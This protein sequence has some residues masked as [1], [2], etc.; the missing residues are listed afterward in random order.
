MNTILVCD[1]NGQII[2]KQCQSCLHSCLTAAISFD[3]A[4][5]GHVLLSTIHTNDSVSA[6]SRL[7]DLGIDYNQIASSLICV[8]SQRLVR[9]NCSK[10]SR[11]F[12]PP[13]EEVQLF[14]NKYPSHLKFYK[15]TG[16]KACDFTGYSGRTVISELFE[17]NREIAFAISS[18]TS[19]T[20]LK[21]IAIKAGMKTM[22]DDGFM[23]TDQISLSELIRVIPIEMIKEFKSRN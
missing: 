10:C 3:A 21:Q 12:K 23:K 2:C 11:S 1:K 19:E 8:L 22:A 20:E 13:K 17:L 18:K 4:Q 9:R 16:C 6:V 5:T 7:L 15:G 14:F